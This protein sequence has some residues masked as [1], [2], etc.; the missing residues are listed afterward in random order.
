M[1]KVID[2]QAAEIQS[3]K[4]NKTLLEGMLHSFKA[5]QDKMSEENRIL[6]R[7]VAIQHNAQTNSASELQA[8]KQQNV[9]LKEENRML[10]QQVLSLRYQLQAH[11]SA[12]MDDFMGGFSP[13]PPDV[14]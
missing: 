8:T 4:S 7:G 1:Q 13:R 6:K 12:P 2:S 10:Q 3:L 14:Y 11:A 5:E 9:Q